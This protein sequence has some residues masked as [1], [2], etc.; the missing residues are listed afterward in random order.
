[1]VKLCA[2]VI[3]KLMVVCFNEMFIQETFPDICKNAKVIDLSKS[4]SDIDF[5]NYRPISRFS[6]ISKDFE[7]KFFL[8]TNDIIF[9]EVQ[10]TLS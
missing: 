6:T 5:F 7:K 4:G 10:N 8:P 3:M 1:M 9:T 2:S